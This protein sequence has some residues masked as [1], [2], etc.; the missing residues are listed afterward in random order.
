[1][2]LVQNRSLA[3]CASPVEAI[4]ELC[5]GF[6]GF[7]PD[8]RAFQE[9]TPTQM[10]EPYRELLCHKQHMTIAL[11]DFHGAPVDL[12]V[13]ATRGEGAHYARKIFLTRRG[14]AQ[15]VELGV[16]RVNLRMIAEP[17]RGQI[18]AQ[19][20]PLGAVLIDNGICRRVEPRWYLR[21]PR[22][23]SILAWFGY[24]THGPF[25]GRI[26]TIFCDE[27][28]AV[29]VLEIATLWETATS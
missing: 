16:A 4:E 7:Q 27:E 17:A 2:S 28:P 26:G 1:M 6:P 18:L 8:P 5:A 10:P 19:R 24:P 11:R 29:D 3:E 15:A 9:Q 23:S 20:R 21:F 12:Y 13:M 22:G 25:F 14:S